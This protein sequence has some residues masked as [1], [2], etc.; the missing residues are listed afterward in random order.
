MQPARRLEQTSTSRRFP[1]S[2][3]TSL[4]LSNE[5]SFLEFAVS[6]LLSSPPL[7]PS[8]PL[9]FYKGKSSR[10]KSLASQRVTDIFRP[11]TVR[12]KRR[13]DSIERKCLGC[14][15]VFLFFP[16]F[17]FKSYFITILIK[18]VYRQ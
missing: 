5:V 8:F 12:S 15:A 11:S 7:L 18:A 4:P 10:G 1:E 2:N 13:S 9:V 14:Y 6:P 17:C 3:R 16:T